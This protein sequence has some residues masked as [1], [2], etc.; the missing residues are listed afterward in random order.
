MLFGYPIKA[1]EDNWFHE[2]LCEILQIIHSSVEVSQQPPTW[3]EIIPEPYRKR[4]QRKKGLKARLDDY[5]ASLEKLTPLEQ[6]QV[7]NAIGSQNEISLL[8]SCQTN[9]ETLSDLPSSIRESVKEL[10]EFSFKKLTDLDI[11]DN[12]YY[13]IYNEIPA[14]TCPFCGYEHFDAPTAPREALDHYLPQSRYSFAAANLHNLVPMGAKCN[15]QYKRAKDILIKE[16]GSRRKSFDPY[17]HHAVVKISLDESQPFAG[18]G[19]LLPQW[20]IKFHPSNISEE[21]ETWNNVFHLCERYKRDVLDPKFNPWLR[22]FSSWC[23]ASAIVTANDQELICAIEKYAAYQECLGIEDRAFLK[24]AVFRMLYVH[25]QQGDQ[26]LINLIRDV[27][28]G[29]ST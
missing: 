10:F 17:N 18:T 27:V 13:L 1:T 16:D 9:C 3:P 29:V 20:E 19:G 12:H 28:S 4:L 15:S 21:I 6:V 25:C 7:Q 8:V 26:R 14:H 22:G 5:R 2:C 23:N 24:A 11:R